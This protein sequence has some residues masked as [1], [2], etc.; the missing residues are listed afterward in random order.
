[1]P[2]YIWYLTLSL[3]LLFAFPSH[4]FP[5][6]LPGVIRNGLHLTLMTDTSSR[7]RSL[8][9][10][11]MWPFPCF[12]SRRFVRSPSQLQKFHSW[13]K[14]GNGRPK[15]RL[16]GPQLF[17]QSYY[18]AAWKL[19]PMNS[20]YAIFSIGCRPQICLRGCLPNL[21]SVPHSAALLIASR[22]HALFVL[23]L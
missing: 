6:P 8:P 3:A 5:F 22:A 20:I 17:H 16:C 13:E 11:S 10:N 4:L 2:A 12:L 23:L 7:K 14:T 18:L 9:F 21:E 15:G 19:A 1:M